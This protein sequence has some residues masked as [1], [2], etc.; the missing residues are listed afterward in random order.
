MKSALRPSGWSTTS[1]VQT[2][3]ALTRSG[4]LFKSMATSITLLVPTG[5]KFVR[6]EHDW[7]SS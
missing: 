7:R 2:L 3:P 5:L 1:V 6:N 4:P